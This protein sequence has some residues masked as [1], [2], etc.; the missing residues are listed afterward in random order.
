MKLATADEMGLPS[1][2]I[3]PNLVLLRI[4]NTVENA[5]LHNLRLQ[6]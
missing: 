2:L 1:Q 5:D 4:E 6:N 3:T